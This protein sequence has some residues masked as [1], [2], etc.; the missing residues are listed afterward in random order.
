MTGR[1]LCVNIVPKRS[2]TAASLAS[3][4]DKLIRY[5]SSRLLGNS[6]SIF[7]GLNQA[8]IASRTS[9]SVQ[10]LH[11]RPHETAASNLLVYRPY[12]HPA[13]SANPKSG[14]GICLA[15]ASDVDANQNALDTCHL[16][17]QVGIS[18]RWSA[19]VTSEG[20]KDLRKREWR[21]GR[22]KLGKQGKVSTTSTTESLFPTF[23]PEI[24]AA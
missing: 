12:L 7:G 23:S 9:P 17:G 14:D 20:S 8:S 22:F 5:R 4:R 2:G 16:I 21:R 18:S 1:G 15:D 24:G 10:E 3:Q 6:V 13:R 19:I 11:F